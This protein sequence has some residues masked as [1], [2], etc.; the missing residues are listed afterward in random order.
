MSSTNRTSSSLDSAELSLRPNR[1]NLMNKF[2]LALGE[3][4]YEIARLQYDFL[5]GQMV[6]DEALA[7]AQVCLG[8]LD[9]AE[10]LRE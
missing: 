4:S 8:L 5:E 3:P 7:F 9:A 2:N 6:P 1:L 10:S